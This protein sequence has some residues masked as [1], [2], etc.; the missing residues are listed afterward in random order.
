MEQGRPS[1]RRKVRRFTAPRREAFLA[2]YGRTGN[3]SAAAK[4]V[5]IDRSTADQRR[6]RDA[7][8]ALDCM[9]AKDAATRLLTGARD[10]FEGV[11]DAERET[12]KRGPHGR[13]MIVAARKGKWCKSV[14]EIVLAVLRRSGNVAGAARAAG[15]SEGTIWARRRQWPAFRERMEEAL[16][17]AEVV[18]E[19]RLATMGNAPGDDEDD[20]GTGT[21]DC[22]LPAPEPFDPDLALRFLK[23][24][25]AKRQGR[26]GGRNGRR[27]ARPP[28]PFAEVKH[29]ILTKLSAFD[30]YQR[31]QK[32]AQGWSEDEEGRL[33]PPGW[34]RKNP[35]AGEDE[36]GG[37]R[38]DC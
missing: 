13:A 37:N 11:A 20:L 24:R 19:F 27:W 35:P 6:K 5:G 2:F 28:R 12:I 10:C 36:G 14:E 32:L 38:D 30:R 15:I 4:A 18:L 21:S 7:Q 9:A 31:A 29:S 1:R 23:W 22:P 3:W 16:D 33:I 8:F 25:E 26:E 34:V 17:E